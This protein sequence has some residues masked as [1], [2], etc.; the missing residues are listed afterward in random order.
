MFSALK[1]VQL[2]NDFESWF[3]AEIVDARYVDEVSEAEFVFATERDRRDFV[4][5]DE[6]RR[7]AAKLGRARDAKSRL[8]RFDCGLQQRG[9]GHR[10][11]GM[12]QANVARKSF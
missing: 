6:Q 11:C 12:V 4:A 7:F 10:G 2:V 8:E 3:I 9:G 5:F 1:L